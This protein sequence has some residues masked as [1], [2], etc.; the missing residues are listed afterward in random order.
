VVCSPLLWLVLSHLLVAELPMLTFE[1]AT[2]ARFVQ[3]NE[4]LVGVSYILLPTRIPHSNAST[5]AHNLHA[6]VRKHAHYTHTHVRAYTHT[7]THTKHFHTHIDIHPHER[8]QT[9]AG[10][11]VYSC[12]GDG[13]LDVSWHETEAAPHHPL[14]RFLTSPSLSEGLGWIQHGIDSTHIFD[15]RVR[16]RL[17]LWH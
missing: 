16:F 8:T 10:K 12:P 11:H 9:H 17:N 4:G 14:T 13:L 2:D 1:M 7:F 15:A 3:G 6:Y 5:Y